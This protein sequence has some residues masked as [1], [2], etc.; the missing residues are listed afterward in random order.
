MVVLL[1]SNKF[2]TYLDSL[3]L[4]KYM[5]ANK[6][7]LQTCPPSCIQITEYNISD[8]CAKRK[9][10]F[11]ELTWLSVR[12]NYMAQFICLCILCLYRDFDEIWNY[13]LKIILT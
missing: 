1:F 12:D 9:G 7:Y 11:D 3:I 8:H 6:Q 4:D 10:H 13:Y 5:P 2:Y